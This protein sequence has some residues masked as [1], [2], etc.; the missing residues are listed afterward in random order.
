MNGLV[1]IQR[2][3]ICVNLP[4]I[5]SDM[6]AVGTNIVTERKTKKVS[7]CQGEAGTR[8]EATAY[9]RQTGHCHSLPH[10]LWDS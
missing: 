6:Q 7:E 10:S 2:G 4:V 5:L 3:E 1:G 9:S 8:P